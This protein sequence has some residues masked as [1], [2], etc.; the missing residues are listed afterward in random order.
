[1]ETATITLTTDRQIGL[2]QRLIQYLGLNIGEKVRIQHRDRRIV[3]ASARSVADELWGTIPLDSAKVQE[4]LDMSET[5]M[6]RL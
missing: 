3:M 6:K 5:F 2:P 1:M 4:V